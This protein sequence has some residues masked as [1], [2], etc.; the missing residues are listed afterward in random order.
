MVSTWDVADSSGQLLH[1]DGEMT[2]ML[3]LLPV[4]QAA[5]LEKAARAQGLTSAQL[6]R[7]LISNFL[8]N[9]G[10]SGDTPRED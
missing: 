2:E 8:R 5:A 9:A 10:V 3:L 1:L 7:R 4:P 6:T